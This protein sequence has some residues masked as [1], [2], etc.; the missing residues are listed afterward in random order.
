MMQHITD[1]DL[2]L[3]SYGETTDSPG[4]EQHLDGCADCRGR[5]GDLQRTMNCVSLTVPDRGAGYEAQVWTRLAPKLG[6]R[7]RR[8]WFRAFRPWAAVAVP[9]LL[10]AIAFLA[11][12]YSSKPPQRHSASVSPELI[13]DRVLVVAVGDHLERSKIALIELANS[14]PRSKDEAGFERRNAENLIE[15]NR[16]YRQTALATGETAMASLLDDLERVL[17]EVAHAPETISAEEWDE[18]RDRVEEQG[19]VFKIRGVESQLRNRA[20]KPADKVTHLPEGVL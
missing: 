11:G 13:R 1:E 6:K 18:L 2:I 17:L 7:E 3:H 4:V 12:R 15:A 9:V 19:L 20:L 8:S 16:L 5:Y 10:V 14:E